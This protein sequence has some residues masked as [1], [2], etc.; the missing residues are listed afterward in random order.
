MDAQFK[1]Q[2]KPGPKPGWAKQLRDESEHLR[3]INGRMLD[4]VQQ[5]ARRV[6]TFN[7]MS[8]WAKLLFILKGGHV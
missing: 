1:L 3:R 2:T 5:L 6:I 8:T 4:D 7:Q